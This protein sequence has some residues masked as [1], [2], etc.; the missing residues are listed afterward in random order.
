VR[1]PAVDTTISLPTDEN[2]RK[3]SESE[4]LSVKN[5]SMSRFEMKDLGDAQ[6]VLGIRPE[7]GVV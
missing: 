4:K 2:T 3:T 6:K 1:Y 7:K 5:E